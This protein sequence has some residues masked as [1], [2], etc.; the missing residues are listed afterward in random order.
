MRHGNAFA[1]ALTLAPFLP[2]QTPLEID[3]DRARVDAVVTD[4]MGRHV[5]GLAQ[6]SH[7]KCARRRPSSWARDHGRIPSRCF[8]DRSR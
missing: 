6:A 3:I 4:S 8:M 2:A 7:D 1:P 5:T